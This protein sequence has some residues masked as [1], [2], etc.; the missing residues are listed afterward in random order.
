MADIGQFFEEN[1][2]MFNNNGDLSGNDFNMPDSEK[3][4]E[5]IN[6]LLGKLG[7]LVSEI[8]EETATEMEM[9]ISNNANVNDVFSKLFKKSNKVNE[10][11]KI[12]WVKK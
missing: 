11:G 4:H 10:N 3:I 7:R 2:K 5:H 1:D 8:A 6:G 12:N 9:D